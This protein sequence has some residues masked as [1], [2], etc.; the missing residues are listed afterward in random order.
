MTL[1]PSWRL[2]AGVASAGALGALVLTALPASASMPASDSVAV[3]SP[4]DSVSKTW[5]GTIPVGSDQTGPCTAGATTDSHASTVTVPGGAYDTSDSTFAFSITWTPSSPAGETTNDEI[6]TVVDQTGKVLG[7]ADTS[8]TT[9]Q[10]TLKNLPG[11]TYTALACGY[12][13]MTAQ[14]YTGTLNVTSTA[15]GSTPVTAPGAPTPAHQ[16]GPGPL[17]TA[18]T[19]V[20]PLLFGGEPG[21]NFDNSPDGVASQR[22]YVDWPVSS[23]QNIGVVNRSE[24]GGLIYRKRFDD[25]TVPAQGAAT[26]DG[27]QTLTC[28]GGGGGDTD[29]SVDPVNGNL[30]FANQESLASQ[31]VGTSTDH[32]T[33][34]LT[35]NT[36]PVV[37]KNATGVDRQ[38]SGHYNGTNTIFLAYHVPEAGEYINR[39][40]RNGATGSWT[41]PPTAQIPGV[42]QSG[43]MIIDN[44]PNNPAV[45]GEHPIY[46]GYLGGIGGTPGFNVGVSLDGANSFATHIIPGGGSAR[47]FT[48]LNV[49]NAGNLYATWADSTTNKT[50]LATSLLSDPANAASPGTKWSKPVVLDAPGVNVSIFPDVVAGDPGRIAVHYYGTQAQATTPDT[51]MKGAGGWYPYVAMSMNALCQWDATSPCDAPTVDQSRIAHQINQDDNICTSGTAC[52]ATMGNRNLLDYFDISLDKAGHLGFVWSD[53]TNQTSLP[54]VKVA[55]Q[56][57]GPSLYADGPTASLP[58]RTDVGSSVTSAGGD[59]KYPIAGNMVTTAKNQPG[60]DLLGTAVRLKDAATMEITMDLADAS[61]LGTFFGGGT[62]KDQ[63]TPLQQA[64]YVARWDYKGNSYYAGANVAAGN[65]TPAFFSGVVNP[66]NGILAAGGGTT[67]YGEKYSADKAATGKVVGNQLVVDVPTKDV[68]TPAAGAELISFGSYSMLGGNDSET[69]LNTL[70]VTVDSTPTFDTP[71]QAGGADLPGP[72]VPEAPYAVLVPLAALLAVGGVRVARRRRRATA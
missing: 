31:L 2:V 44:G 42:T 57:T 28:G 60:Q 64:K 30:I 27:R 35:A 38:W 15:K 13:N 68:G 19:V 63:L 52:A 61:K 71:L 26:C 7:T 1:R 56:A 34:I 55:R 4:P 5:T 17:F 51:V 24:D 72:V 11:G 70:P 37:G 3:P 46:I 43:S 21:F 40:D 58:T 53:T 48:K 65:N 23:R 32:G 59:A 18:A 39:S 54:Y 10:V 16:S 69:L 49:D 20:D 33:T 45:K 12:L 41:I 47:S 66:N 25:D 67:P 22:S 6:L 9:E 8:A 50:L 29:I 14:P 62:G 36:D